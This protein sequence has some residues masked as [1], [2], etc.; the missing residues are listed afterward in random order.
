MKAGGT[1]PPG[2][3]AALHLTNEGSSKLLAVL[4]AATC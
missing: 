3:G 1:L 2:E 4:P